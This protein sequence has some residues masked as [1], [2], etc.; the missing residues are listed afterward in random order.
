MNKL[1]YKRTIVDSCY[2]HLGGILGETLFKF[3]LKEKWIENSDGE[4]NITDKGW[5]ELE[6]MGLDIDMLRNTKR[7]IV[8][9]CLQSNYGIFHEHIGAHLGSLLMELMIDLNWLVKKDEKRFELTD[10]GISGLESLGVE[11]KKFV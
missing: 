2:D 5:E 4:Y 9:I 11:I 10:T 1:I 3:L 6:T 8:N 7:K